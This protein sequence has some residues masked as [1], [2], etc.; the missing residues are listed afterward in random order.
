MKVFFT[1][2]LISLFSFANAQNKQA[3]SY[4]TKVQEGLYLL[5][6]GNYEMAQGNFEAAYQMDS[7]TANINYLIGLCYLNSAQ[8]KAS[9]ER[10]FA[11]A[12]NKISRSYRSDDPEE[13]SASPLA[14]LYYGKALHINYKFDQAIAQYDAFT[15]KYA[16]SK[17]L[18]KMAA[19]EKA[20]S[21]VAKEIVANPL[22]IK[23]ENLGD[24]VN[25]VYAEYSPV[26]SADE[27]TLIFTTRR[28]NSTGGLRLPDGQYFED[29][30]ACYKDN[31][32]N[33]SKPVS[34]S[35][36]VN[37][38]GNEASINL[39]PDGQTLIVYRDDAGNGNIYYSTFEGKDWSPLK[40]FGSDVN[41]KYFESHAC[42]NVDGTILFF[43]SDRPGGFGGRDIYR[44]I[45]LPNG[46][47][48]KALNVGSEI[49]SAED[50]DGAFMHP[51]GTTFFFASKGK[52]SMG[53]FDILFATLNEDN[54]FTD[55]SN[56]GYP[57]N[58]TDDDV[59]YVTSPDGKRGY[60]TSAKEGGHGEKDIYRLSIPESKEPP[61]ALFRGQIQVAPGEKLPDNLLVVVTDKTT[62]K[63]VGTYL[64]KP[65]NGTFATILP[66]GQEYNFSYQTSNGEEFYTED[67]FVTNEV[68]YKEINRDVALEPVKLTGKVKAKEKAILLNV[69]TLEN[70]RT[71]TV[72][73]GAK[74]TV[75]EEGLENRNY[76]S[77]TK[78]RFD[79]IELQKDKKYNVFAELG[80]NKSL[81]A[82][83]NTA[84]VKSGKIVNQILYLKT[85]PTKVTSKEL[86][87]GVIVKNSRTLKIVPNANI[88]LTDSDGENYDVTTNEKGEIEGIELSPDTKYKLRATSADGGSIS[89][90]QSLTTVGVKGQKKFTKT[91]FIDEEDTTEPDY[92]PITAR[93]KITSKNLL[94]G[95]IVRNSKSFKIIPNVKI[96]LV[97]ADGEFYDVTT[98]DKGEIKGIELSP[99]TKYELM[100]T[101]DQGTMS[102]KQNFST[103][104]VKGQ[105][106]FNKTLYIDQDMGSDNGEFR[107][108][109]KRK[110]ITSSQ[111][112][113]GVIV[114]NAKTFKII[115]NVKITLIDADGEYYDVTTNDKGEISGIEL[116]PDTK[117][118]VLATSE[119]GSTS[120]RQMF[121]TEGVKEKKF[122]KTLYLDQGGED[123][124]AE[125]SSEFNTTYKY[126][127]DDLE[128]EDGAFKGF[129][130]QLVERSKAGPVRVKILTG[131]SKVPTTKYSTNENLA[132][133]R[134]TNLEAKIKKSVINRGGKNENITYTKSGEVGGPEYKGDAN[135]GREIYEKY[136]FG[137]ATIK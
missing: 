53:G 63:I 100:A 77:N 58:T 82:V 13:K 51:D 117:Y 9:A 88:T 19:K 66:P 81:V 62:G 90:E 89:E 21:L 102:K 76:T 43:T 50:E 44:C 8:K 72:V 98:N 17:D 29:I 70:S 123:V 41:S 125:A 25:S 103:E 38:D 135:S 113:L 97:D 109:S 24:S 114:K 5:L 1:V 16:D 6:E 15:A 130:T 59:F 111:L 124:A 3:D 61:L 60:F 91:L 108:L 45:K 67:I 92:K 47:W 74:I 112:L 73:S 56:I 121:S 20:T 23:I 31:A 96:T 64:P 106:T 128:T 122:S 132:N 93:K 54:K 39:T 32:G 28:P 22:N 105:K 126:N 99:N 129:V 11:K 136:Q 133:S 34:L 33:W 36:N 79:G 120:K 84:G 69:V 83:V 40:E 86:K 48:S 65:A 14:Q 49:N 104:G 134:A 46:N 27:R 68:S 110:K 107:A 12:I 127:V 115:P 75:E 131:A 94:L 78:G 80:E 116:S 18:K 71:K 87:L 35:Q 85:K 7:S 95:V 30:V 118:E 4:K 52:K 55:I 26:L 10:H 42:L 119:N 37:T 2:A 137:K 57:I 101:N